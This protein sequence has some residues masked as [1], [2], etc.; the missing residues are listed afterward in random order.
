[1]NCSF[2]QSLKGTV[3]S[4]FKEYFCAYQTTLFRTPTCVLYGGKGHP[5]T[6]GRNMNCGFFQGLS[7]SPTSCNWFNVIKEQPLNKMISGL[8]T[9]LDI[10]EDTM[11]GIGGQCVLQYWART[12]CAKHCKKLD[13]GRLPPQSDNLEQLHLHH[14]TSYLIIYSNSS[15]RCGDLF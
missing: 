9:D 2:F 1:M 5:R 3:L 10:S 12:W 8:T 13:I 4:V 15:I 14:N 7:S 11:L 6:E